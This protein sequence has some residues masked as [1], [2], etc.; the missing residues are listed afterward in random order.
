MLKFFTQRKIKMVWK[1]SYNDR[2]SYLIGT[3]HM[4]GYK[5][6]S[7]IEDF[8]GNSDRVI[9]ECCL[10]EENLK[11]VLSAGVDKPKIS[12][13]ELIDRDTISSLA[14]TFLNV[15]FKENLKKIEILNF[16]NL[17][18]AYMDEIERVLKKYTHWASFF[19][20]WY[21]FLRLIDW[22][23]SMDVEA[24]ILA[25]RMNKKLFFLEN[26][27]EQIEAME[28][29]PPERIV[30]FLKKSTHWK[31]YTEKF[32]K[33]YLKG[34]LDELMINTSE[35]PTRCESI[36]DKR[37]S[38]FFERILPHIKKGKSSIFV[39]ITHILGLIRLMQ[40][41]GLKVSHYER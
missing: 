36:I 21:D 32:A 27:K 26:P 4:F 19:S 35:F 24:Q 8:V 13:F 37:D 3:T 17:K 10:D 33:L 31:S 2:E 22:K 29:I 9:L 11:R 38:V 7:C 40:K 1:V 16:T 41:E 5:F 25:Q 30:N 23:Y 6:T 12:L 15:S 28:G 34:K 39:G 14:D 18:K 20:I